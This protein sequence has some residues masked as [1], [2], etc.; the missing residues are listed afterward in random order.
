MSDN[1]G[2]QTHK[3]GLSGFGREA[4]R[5]SWLVPVGPRARGQLDCQRQSGNASV[6]VNVNHA[7]HT[8]TLSL[9]CIGVYT[10]FARSMKSDYD[11]G[12]SPDEYTTT[13]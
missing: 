9:A 7:I 12:E 8:R 3:H 6:F 1:P 10:L 11:N 2:S 4:I 13:Q 5:T